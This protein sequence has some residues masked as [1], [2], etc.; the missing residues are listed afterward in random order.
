MSQEG[1]GFSAILVG[2][3]TIGALL[4]EKLI[5]DQHFSQVKVV[6]KNG[7]KIEPYLKYEKVSR[8]H[9]LKKISKTDF[10]FL[11]IKPQDYRKINLKV[12]HQTTLVSVMAG[13][14]LKELLTRHDTENVIRL[15]TNTPLTVGMGMTALYPNPKVEPVKK[16]LVLQLF[17]EMGQVVELSSDDQMDRFTT[18]AGSGPAYVF[19]FILNYYMAAE[20]L[21]EKH[22][23]YSF[24]LQ[25][26]LGA[27]EMLKR[28]KNISSLISQVSSK[29]G[30]TEAALK[31]FSEEDLEITL[32]KA[33]EAGYNRAVELGSNPL[34]G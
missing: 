14:S 23:T 12:S 24:V 20:R 19:S 1:K 27:V 18:I 7:H 13:I 28:S 3:G 25:T 22:D 31:V 4:L 21:M 16:D 2:C 32:Q 9:D 17:S 10:I 11:A 5:Q 29:G 34:L 30:T 26:I 33:L 8:V 6:D 15:M